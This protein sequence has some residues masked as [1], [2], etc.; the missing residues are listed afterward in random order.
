MSLF[1]FGRRVT[2]NRFDYKPRYYNPAKE[3]LES[4]LKMI[5]N[6]DNAMD[7]DSIRER[8]SLG[9][10]YRTGRGESYRNES[11]KSN[12]RVVIILFALLLL[13]VLLINSP[14]ILKLLS[15]LDGSQVQ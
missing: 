9:L 11:R 15:Y 4:R 1:G 3:E 13:T 6:Q 8:I 14:K 2:P 10:K 5:N 7:P 12:L